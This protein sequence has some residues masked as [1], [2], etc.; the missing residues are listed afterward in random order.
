MNSIDLLIDT[1]Y[2]VTEKHGNQK[3]PGR[4]GSYMGHLFAVFTEVSSAHLAQPDFDLTLAQ[5]LAALHDIIEDTPTSYDQL[6]SAYGRTIADGVQA[7]SKDPTVDK[8]LQITDSLDRIRQQ[9]R[10]V[11]IVKLADRISNLRQPPSFWSDEK[12]IDYHQKAIEIGDALE[13]CHIY[14]ENRLKEKIKAYEKYLHKE[15]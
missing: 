12:I 5:M 13:G 14:L 8:T 11:W 7:L 10:E 4:Q 9:P 2:Y 6:L 3:L 1:I 15:S